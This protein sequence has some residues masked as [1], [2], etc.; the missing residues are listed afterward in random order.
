MRSFL[1]PLASLF[2]VLYPTNEKQWSPYG[3]AF[4]PQTGMGPR[5]LDLDRHGINLWSAPSPPETSISWRMCGCLDG[6]AE[7][8]GRHIE[9]KVYVLLHDVCQVYPK[10][11]LRSHY[12]RHG[13][14]DCSGHLFC[15]MESQF[16]GMAEL[17]GES[18][19]LVQ[20]LQQ[21]SLV[22]LQ[23]SHHVQSHPSLTCC[24]ICSAI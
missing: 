9:E 18:L 10:M 11:S 17:S 20:V 5:R 8:L 1:V 13:W 3:L 14:T 22:G 7:K 19:A 24:S 23:H 6:C 12:G 16:C 2:S 21:V 15:G 4:N